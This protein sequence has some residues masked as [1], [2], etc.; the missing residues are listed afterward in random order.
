MHGD[1]LSLGSND[2]GMNCTE[3]SIVLGDE[4]YG[5]EMS[6]NG[7]AQDA[8]WLLIFRML[9]MCYWFYDYH[10]G[11]TVGVVLPWFHHPYHG[12]TFLKHG[13]TMRTMVTAYL[14]W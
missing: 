8:S 4:S 12:V 5:D 7:I 6:S 1:E 14:P 10:G 9:Y 3:S 13:F 2:L 11:N